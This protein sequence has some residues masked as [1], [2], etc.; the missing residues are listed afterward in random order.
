VSAGEKE[1]ETRGR[2]RR[3]DCRRVF[4]LIDLGNRDGS[5]WYDLSARDPRRRLGEVGR[6]EAGDVAETRSVDDEDLGRTREKKVRN[7]MG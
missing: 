3:T 7:R 6:G 5:V 2:R 4:A 1:R